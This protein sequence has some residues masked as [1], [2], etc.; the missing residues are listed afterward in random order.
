MEKQQ[1]A[2]PIAIDAT[3]LCWLDGAGSL[4][5]NGRCRAVGAEF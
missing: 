1:H 2:T 4:G 5:F 3:E